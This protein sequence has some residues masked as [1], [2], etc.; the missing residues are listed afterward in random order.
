[1]MSV[2]A[3]HPA[4]NCVNGVCSAG[5]S[6]PV[7]APAGIPVSDSFYFVHQT[8]DGDGSLTVRIDS[9]TDTLQPLGHAS[10]PDPASR[11]T[12]G[13]AGILIKAS[14]TPGSAY[15][16]VLATSGH[17]VRMQYDYTHDLAG[18]PAAVSPAD[19]RWLRLVRSGD[20]I[21][22][23]ESADGRNW[24]ELGTATLPGLAE[25]VQAGMFATSP[26]YSEDT[27]LLGGLEST[28]Y[29]STAAAGMDH[30]TRQGRW[31]DGQWT[32]TAFG[33]ASGSYTADSGPQDTAYRLTGSG[34]I[35]PGADLKDTAQLAEAGAF[36]ALIVLTVLATQFITA[37]FKHRL[38]GSSVAASPRR[39]RIL[40]AK[41]V[42]VF[43]TAAAAGLAASAVSV[44][45]FDRIWPAGALYR[46]SAA[47][48]ARVILGTSLL[49]GV[50]AVFALAL[51]TIVRRSA[52]VI[53]TV[54]ILI[55][56]PYILGIGSLLPGGAAQW[57]L[58]VTPAA[59]FAIQQTIP[60]YPQVD[61]LYLPY[62]GYFPL[63]PWAGFAVLCGYTAVALGVAWLVLR[64]RDVTR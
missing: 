38:L 57:L 18:S 59:A 39:G 10:A 5:P 19:P 41:A 47:T 21:S 56:L 33:G 53:A 12:W 61:N 4:Q 23:Y 35:A 62:A 26:Q 31:P 55:V 11:E 13:K 6:A 58:R 29:A 51:G 24:T 28:A 32:G 45:V 37:E 44:P 54:L 52:V 3:A 8:L 43:G 46:V 17:G 64:R 49:L 60:V 7:Y 48:E 63:A 42:V 30:V 1:M 25:T 40:A 16:A 50:A 9:L 36:L 15:A 27:Q 14:A 22:G 2:S 34:D 20:V